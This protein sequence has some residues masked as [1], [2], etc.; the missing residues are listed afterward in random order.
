MTL[1]RAGS[2]RGFLLAYRRLVAR[3]PVHAIYAEGDLPP[4]VAKDTEFS[5]V[6]AQQR[7]PGADA[8]TAKEALPGRPGAE[9]RQAGDQF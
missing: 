4:E 2:P 3:S 1:L 5:A 9:K 6:Q 8:I 7:T